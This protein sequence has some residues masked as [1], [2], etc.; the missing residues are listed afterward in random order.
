MNS[1]NGFE[2]ALTEAPRHVALTMSGPNLS[3]EVVELMK[4]R[5][6]EATQLNRSATHGGKPWQWWITNP[7]PAHERIAT[8]AGW[9]LER[10]I[11]HLA[12]ALDQP[13][14]ACATV[15]TLTTRPFEAA[16]DSDAL[17]SINNRAFEWHPDQ[18]DWTAEEFQRSLAQPW[19][20]PSD[21]LMALD[22]DGN[23][24]GFCWMKIH[25][26]GVPTGEIFLIAI[27]P[28]AAGA[29]L[30]TQLVCVS[31]LHILQRGCQRA[32]LWCEASNS[33]A[34]RLYD[35]VGFEVI[36]TEV[37]YGAPESP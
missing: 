26:P 23:P 22:A 31:L 30:G 21:I 13:P 12:I 33:R 4:R 17:R 20:A 35:K 24:I 14:Q 36:G 25:N 32:E 11:F 28:D 8:E 27:D 18:H 29:G 7:T 1:S 37:A 34:L 6:A 3:P 10:T 19:V 2:W 16:R 9:R 15:P 5:L